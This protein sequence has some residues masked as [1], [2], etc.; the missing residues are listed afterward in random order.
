MK[1]PLCIQ[2]TDSLTSLLASRHQEAEH[3]LPQAFGMLKTP[4]YGSVD[5]RNAGYKIAPIDTN[6]YP[7]GFN[8]LSQDDETLA[9]K[10]FRH[11]IDCLQPNAQKIL[12]IPENHTRNFAYFKNVR[13]LQQLLQ[14][15][16]FDV[17]LGTYQND[18]TDP[19]MLPILQ[20]LGLAVSV[21]KRQEERISL[22][23]FDPDLVL[24]NNDLSQGTPALIQ[25]IAQ[26]VIPHPQLGWQTRT[27]SQHF[28][29][30]K[31]IAAAFAKHF[32]IDPWLIDCGYSTHDNI[33]LS[34]PEDNQQLVT[35]SQHLAHNI[36]QKYQQYQIK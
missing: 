21:I 25:N 2:K 34:K 24:L 18:L 35:A 10:A 3:W 16:G 20:E 19:S 17:Q 9:V 4:V 26:P 11:T 15:A 14:Q 33:D 12:L 28:S 32:A 8:N 6:L 23:G 22:E 31:D 1:Q 36:Q 7:A 5:L 27:K 30:Y 29:Y 13:R